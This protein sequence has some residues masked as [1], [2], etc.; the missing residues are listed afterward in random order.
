MTRPPLFR[1]VLPALAL[2]VLMTGGQSAV[3]AEPKN[4]IKPPPETYEVPLRFARHDFEA[5][6]YNTLSCRVLYNENDFTP[7][8]VNKPTPAPSSPNYREK[9]GEAGYLG[10]DNFPQ[11]A[12]VQWT[13]LDGMKHRARVDMARIFKDQLVWHKVP[14][15]EMTDFYS[16]SV[17]GEPNI[18]LEVNDRTINVYMMMLIPTK[19]EQIT[20]NR[21]SYFR[22]DVL[23][24]WTHTY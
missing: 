16:G 11:P 15:Q 10:I 22:N 3:S 7:Y 14:K 19:T 20:G 1:C 2:V 5:L 24:V 12:D 4:P 17:A 6:C 8:A 18:Y 21:Y 13:S 23:L 9:W